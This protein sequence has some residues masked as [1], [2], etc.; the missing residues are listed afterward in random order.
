MV[1]TQNILFIFLTT[2]LFHFSMCNLISENEII[3]QNETTGESI[4]LGEISKPPLD[5]RTYLGVLLPNGMKVIL[6]SDPNTTKAAAALSVSVGS[7]NDP[8]DF[9]GMAHF[10]EHMLFLGSQKYRDENSFHKFI[11]EHG[12]EMKVV[13][14]DC[15]IFT[16]FGVL[17]I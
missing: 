12:K 15:S 3:P 2:A 7:I 5:R 4:L 16:Q 14:I 11:S 1:F 6:V 13:E 8:D 10:L 9:L 17:M